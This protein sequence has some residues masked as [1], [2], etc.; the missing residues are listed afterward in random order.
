LK[1]TK[2]N[3]S[4]AMVSLRSFV[5]AMKE[6]SPEAEDSES[7]DM[8]A[9]VSNAGAAMDEMRKTV[10]DLR[11]DKRDLVKELEIVKTENDETMVELAA[12]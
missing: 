6:D 10:A 7:T 1:D 2:D 3:Q 9:V 5:T 12:R 4:S 8:E 11:D